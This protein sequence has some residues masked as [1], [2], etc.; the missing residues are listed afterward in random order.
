MFIVKTFSGPSAQ[1]EVFLNS[2]TTGCTDEGTAYKAFASG[3]AGW[4]T[5]G[6]CLEESFGEKGIAV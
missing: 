3:E 5:A 4:R 1:P 2:E 6:F